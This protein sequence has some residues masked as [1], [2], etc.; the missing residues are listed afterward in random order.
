[1]EFQRKDQASAIDKLNNRIIDLEHQLKNKGEF[2]SHAVH[3]LKGYIHNIYFL[4]DY[5][6]SYWQDR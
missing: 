2:L 4:I 3:E 5:L 6:E 1:M